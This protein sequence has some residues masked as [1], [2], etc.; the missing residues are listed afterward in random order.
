MAF[1]TYVFTGYW[2]RKPTIFACP[3]SQ[4]LLTYYIG[5][6]TACSD[7]CNT[8]QVGLLRNDKQFRVTR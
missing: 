3:Y 6:S 5:S 8:L 2:T 7:L 4:C 1:M